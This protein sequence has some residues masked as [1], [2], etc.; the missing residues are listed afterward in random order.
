MK[1]YNYTFVSFYSF[2]RGWGR[3]GL[4]VTVDL[5]EEG[6]GPNYISHN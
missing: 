6:E 3:Y 1:F 2:I 4:E 5:M